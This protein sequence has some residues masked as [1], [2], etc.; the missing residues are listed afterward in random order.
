M[1]TTTALLTAEQFFE[2]PDPGCPADLVRGEVVMMNMPG[3]QHGVI[4]ARIARYVGT[5][6][7]Q[8]DLGSVLSNDSGIITERGPDTVRGADVAFYS[9]ARVPKHETPLGYPKEKPELVFEVKSPYDR[10]KEIHR[11]IG[12]YLSAGVLIVCVVDPETETVV[13]YSADKR[14]ATYQIDDVL[15]LDVLPGFAVAVRK[16]FHA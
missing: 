2:L 12:E 13:A 8:N 14:D 1:A 9:Y 15:T 11:K 10:W 5:F 4:C 6:A 7:D 16:L 3:Y